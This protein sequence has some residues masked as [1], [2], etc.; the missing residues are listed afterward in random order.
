MKVLASGTKGT[1]IVETNEREL[2]NALGFASEFD[3]QWRILRDKNR[4][5]L[6]PIGYTFNIAQAH[7]FFASLQLKER[8]AKD[9]AGLLRSLADMITNGLPTLIVAPLDTTQETD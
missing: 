5:S 6:W 1:L 2:A 8:Q 4:N 9:A 3:Q 7:D